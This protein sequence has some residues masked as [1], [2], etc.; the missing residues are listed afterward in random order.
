MN[1]VHTTERL[2]QEVRSRPPLWDQK[3]LNYHNRLVVNTQWQEIADLLQVN[4]EYL[5]F[6]HVSC[7]KTTDYINCREHIFQIINIHMLPDF[8][9]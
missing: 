4:S 1:N 8:I 2:I 9:C 5:I 3:H 6:I 7:N